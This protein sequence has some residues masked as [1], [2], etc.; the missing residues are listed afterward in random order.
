VAV[1]RWIATTSEVPGF[2]VGSGRPGVELGSLVG[3]SARNGT[4]SSCTSLLEAVD[5]A[6]DRSARRDPE[7]EVSW[8]KIRHIERIDSSEPVYDLCLDRHHCFVANNMVVHNCIIFIDEID[9]V[10]DMDLLGPDVDVREQ[11]LPH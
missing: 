9:A 6:D 8:A 2:S 4:T 10:G 1:P 7:P 5:E 11:V 3:G